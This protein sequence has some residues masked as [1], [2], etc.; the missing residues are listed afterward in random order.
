V[1]VSRT[2]SA[3][4]LKTLGNKLS[5]QL[6]AEKPK[7]P[8]SIV[9]MPGSKIDPDTGLPLQ[10]YATRFDEK[11]PLR[12]VLIKPG[13]YK[14]GVPEE[15]KHR[16]E[17]S[18]RAVRIKEP[19]YMATHETTNEQYQKFF[20]DAGEAQAGSKWQASS[21]KWAKPRNIAPLDNHLPVTNVTPEQAEAF[22]T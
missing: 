20:A 5:I 9:A 2:V 19:Y 17:A 8:S 10:V 15:M 14:F 3:D 13:K 21:K 1:T 7:L 12:L 18:E 6:E 4:E 11:E 16:N 22:C